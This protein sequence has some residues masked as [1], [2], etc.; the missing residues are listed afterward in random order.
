M[1]WS[2]LFG[3]QELEGGFVIFGNEARI[4]G[5]MVALRNKASGFRFRFAGSVRRRRFGGRNRGLIL[6]ISRQFRRS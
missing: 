5:F 4:I 3:T 1:L 2:D 6:F